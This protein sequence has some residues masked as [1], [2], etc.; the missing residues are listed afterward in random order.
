MRLCTPERMAQQPWGK[1]SEF[2]GSL[3]GDYLE[4]PETFAVQPTIPNAV[5]SPQMLPNKMPVHYRALRFPFL[6]G[7]IVTDLVTDKRVAAHTE[8]LSACGCFIETATPFP[9]ATKVRLQ[10]SRDGQN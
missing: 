10:I 2:D 7:V 1:W 8:D 5:I 4:P 3:N 9:V 6:A